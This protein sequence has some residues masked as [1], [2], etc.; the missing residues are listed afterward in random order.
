MHRKFPWWSVPNLPTKQVLFSVLIAFFVVF[1]TLRGVLFFWIDKQEMPIP[2]MPPWKVAV[3]KLSHNIPWPA[4]PK[5]HLDRTLK[6]TTAI[7]HTDSK[8][9]HTLNGSLA[10]MEE[11]LDLLDKDE[12]THDLSEFSDLNFERIVAQVSL[13]NRGYFFLVPRGK[14]IF[15]KF[16]QLDFAYAKL[17]NPSVEYRV[18]FGVEKMVRQIYFN[19]DIEQANTIRNELKAM[20]AADSGDIRKAAIDLY[21]GYALCLANNQDGASYIQTANETIHGN[22]T[23]MLAEFNWDF[24]YFA[25]IKKNNPAGSACINSMMNA[26]NYKMKGE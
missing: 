21:Y 1:A 13:M 10:R 20:V 9:D 11:A 15:D 3:L 17:E 22:L 23:W 25:A 7:L 19:H 24:G 8:I 16:K 26:L 4:S 12:R 2:A 5:E 6:L 18:I 14:M